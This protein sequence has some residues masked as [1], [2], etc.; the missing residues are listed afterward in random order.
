MYPFIQ[1]REEWETLRI[2][3]VLDINSTLAIHQDHDS[4]HQLVSL[5][6]YL[7]DFLAADQDR[8]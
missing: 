1:Y 4:H 7:D 5:S 6:G 2:S 8:S 3:F